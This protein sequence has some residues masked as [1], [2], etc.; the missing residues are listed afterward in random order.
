[1]RAVV[2]LGLFGCVAL[3]LMP[4]GCASSMENTPFRQVASGA[5]A[6]LPQT[7]AARLQECVETYG[8][9]LSS[10]Y[11]KVHYR[12][13]VDPGGRIVDVATSEVAE[14]APDFAA[15]TRIVLRD[16]TVSER[17]LSFRH[18]GSLGS[19]NGQTPAARGLMGDVTVLGAEVALQEL[20]VGVAGTTVVFAVIVV[21]AVS[22]VKDIVEAVDEDQENRRR[23]NEKRTECLQTYRSGKDGPTRG[24]SR[25]QACY[26]TCV[27]LK[28][29]W[30]SHVYLD[31]KF[32]SCK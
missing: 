24:A 21:L 20:L 14:D 29:E 8:D 6:P 11:S 26:N 25:C 31:R 9:Q 10:S 4:L 3:T 23:C 18:S 27:G 19:T 13:R 17:M 5:G 16:M 1:M 2:A 28:G 32:V 15:C 7:T 12:V 30:P 22:G